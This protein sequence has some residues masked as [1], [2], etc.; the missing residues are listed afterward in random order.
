[1]INFLKRSV[2]RRHSVDFT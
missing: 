2:L 1:V